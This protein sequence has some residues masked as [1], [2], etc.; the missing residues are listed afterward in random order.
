MALK[1]RGNYNY[2]PDGA[3]K[4]AARFV[5][6]FHMVFGIFFAMMGLSVLPVVGLFALPFILAGGFFA[7]NGWRVASLKAPEMTTVRGEER[8]FASSLKFNPPAR[9]DRSGARSGASVSRPSGTAKKKSAPVQEQRPVFRRR[10]PEPEELTHDH[11]RPMGDTVES[12]LEQLRT[13]KEAGLYTEE[14]Y[15]EK[16]R[17]IL[18]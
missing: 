12:Q 8:Q 6:I 13:L 3:G 11:I 10:D 1:N 15:R 5:G 16:R 2:R 14:E 17:S 9:P 7:W 18:K 4:A